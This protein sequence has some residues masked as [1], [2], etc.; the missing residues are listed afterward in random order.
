MS[1][2]REK[3]KS[4]IEGY[5][6]ACCPHRKMT[7]V[8]GKNGTD[9]FIKCSKCGNFLHVEIKDDTVLVERKNS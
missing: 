6:Y 2:L 5:Y 4:V 7:L 1:E 9:T 3:H 8:H